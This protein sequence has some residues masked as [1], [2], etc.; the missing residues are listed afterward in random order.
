MARATP[1]KV[2]VRVNLGVLELSGEW[3][4]NNAERDAAWE[5]YVEL[6]TRV[7]V[8]PLSPDEGLLREALSSLYSVFASTRAILRKYGPDIAERKPSGQYNFA[9]LAV[10]IL[11]TGI[12]PLLARWHPEL[13]D[14]EGQRTAL[15]S[16]AS[17]ERAWPLAAALRTELDDARI[18]LTDFAA[19]LATACGVPNLLDTIPTPPPP[20]LDTAP[21]AGGPT[22]DQAPGLDHPSTP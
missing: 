4:P 11:H 5:L 6:I 9:F 20:S 8:V 15:V 22:A 13:Q 2:G 7:S 10:T 16:I 19:A 17:H 18:A 21:P 1:T 12:R 3:E 14:W